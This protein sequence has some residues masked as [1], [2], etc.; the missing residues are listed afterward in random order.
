MG[1]RGGLPA[2]SPAN[3]AFSFLLFPHPP[4]RARRALFPAGRGRILVFL[5]KGLRPL[6]PR[7]LNP[8]GTGTGRQTTRPAG[9]RRGGSRPPTLPLACF[10]AP[11]PP[12]PLPLRGRGRFLAFLCKGLRP[13]HPRGWMGRGTYSLC[14]AGTPRKG[15]CGSPQKR[16]EAAPYEQ[17]RQPRRGGTGGDG[18]IRR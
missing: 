4:V 2:L 14:H 13:L 16:Q 8:G 9:G 7:G 15:A 18:T 17:C 5:C 11:I 3:S 10:P 1:G 6:H 12:A